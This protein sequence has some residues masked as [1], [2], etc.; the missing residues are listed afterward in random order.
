MMNNSAV[1][2]AA[3]E[4]ERKKAEDADIK[5]RRSNVLPLGSGGSLDTYAM[6]FRAFHRDAQK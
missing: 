4:K 1:A 5:T 3:I 2:E 6:A